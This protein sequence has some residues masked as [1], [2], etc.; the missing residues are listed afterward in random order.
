MHAIEPIGYFQSSA[1]ERYSVGRQG[2]IIK[3]QGTIILNSRCNFEQALEDL[4]GFERIWLIYGF[5][6]NNQW[7]PKVLPPRGDKKRGVFAT[8]SPHRPNFLGLTCVKLRSVKGLKLEIEEHDLLDGTPI[9]DI[10]PYLIY[11]DSYPTIK[12]GWVGELET[13]KKFSVVWSTKALEKT[14][15][16]KAHFEIDI[17]ENIHPRLQMN[18]FPTKSNRI[19]LVGENVYEIAYKSWRL[20]FNVDEDIVHIQDVSSGYKPSETSS[21]WNDLPIHSAF[22]MKFNLA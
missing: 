9:F 1:D 6:R 11:A 12:Q 18:P 15:Y 8:R 16:L 21:K 4:E 7:K 2:G 22:L 20:S 19:R 10:K 13:Q 17:Q 5:H 14:D 3:N